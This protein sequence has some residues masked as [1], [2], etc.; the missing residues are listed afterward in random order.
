MVMPESDVDGIRQPDIWPH[1]PF[2]PVKTKQSKPGAFPAIGLLV[3]PRALEMLD[4]V[5]PG[6]MLYRAE[7]PYSVFEINLF[8]LQDGAET[9]VKQLASA[10]RKDYPSPEALCE[11]WRVD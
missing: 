11:M 8:E 5:T 1:Y 2:L 6:F 10:P 9:I 4:A 3:D 7:A